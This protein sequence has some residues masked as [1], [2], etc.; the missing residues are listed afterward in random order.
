MT[1]NDFRPYW[2]LMAMIIMTAITWGVG[3]LDIQYKS[4]G[5]LAFDDGF[6]GAL[7]DWTPAGDPLNITLSEAAV[8][9]ERNSPERSYAM[10]TFPLPPAEELNSR[11]L[12]VRGQIA[13]L[14][15][16]TPIEPERV[17][18]FMIWFQDEANEPINYLTVQALTGDFPKYR[19][20]RIV[21][22]PD[23]ARYFVTTLINR[24]SDG[25]FEL[26]DA[27]VE[28]VSTSTVYRL[29]SPLIYSTWAV[30]LIIAML[31]L[32]HNG[33]WA[34]GVTVTALLALTLVGVLLP[35][36]VTTAH[37]LPAYQKLAS[38]LSFQHTEPLGVAYKIG[39][40]I[41]FFALSL[42]LMLNRHSLGLSAFAI[43]AFMIV[44]ALAT[45]GLQLHLFSRSTRLLDI[46]IDL[47]GVIL[48]WIIASALHALIRPSHRAAAEQ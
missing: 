26:T 31:W 23:E 29:I 39:H 9:I 44:F 48:G 32:V 10:R 45:E 2:F 41:F 5:S 47:A 8:R 14:T 7:S 17:A 25:A 1:Q 18:A 43:L 19:A 37:I 27:S 11:Y 46:G 38:A 42:I 40:F 36:S 6:P 34:I 33:S 15:Q 22:V 13:T 30:M 16:A 28:L 4:E 12:R 24:E 21:N 35:E 20:E 3:L